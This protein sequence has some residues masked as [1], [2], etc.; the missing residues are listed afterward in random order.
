MCFTRSFSPNFLT[1]G[2]PLCTF[3]ATVVILR[4]KRIFCLAGTPV[5]IEITVNIAFIYSVFFGNGFNQKPS[6][7]D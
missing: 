2:L 1:V 6:A 5:F 3:A 7:F 4:Q